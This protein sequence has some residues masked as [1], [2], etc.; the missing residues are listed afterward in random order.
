MENKP[1]IKFST[2]AK[3]VFSLGVLIAGGYN[4]LL[5]GAPQGMAIGIICMIYHY[6]LVL[7]VR[8]DIIE[9]KLDILLPPPAKEVTDESNG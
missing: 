7:D 8:N 9:A 6:L 1:V 5:A 2:K 4:L 3:S